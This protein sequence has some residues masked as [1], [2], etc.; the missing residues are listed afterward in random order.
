MTYL[1][2]VFLCICM[3]FLLFKLSKKVELDKNK[4]NEY[5]ALQVKINDMEHLC[6]VLENK[7]DEYNQSIENY[8]NKILDIQNKYQ[9]ALNKKSND[10]DKFFEQQ[11]QFRQ[12]QLDEE[13]TIRAND[14]ET[15]LQLNYYT[16]K[17]KYDQLNEKLNEQ[18]EKIIAEAEKSQNNIIEETK[19]P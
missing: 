17:H 6:D 13:F 4:I 16:S 2:I 12:T 9:E 14:K 8:Q 11:K 5:N 18:T 1:I 7:I 3:F 19:S 10:L 15:E